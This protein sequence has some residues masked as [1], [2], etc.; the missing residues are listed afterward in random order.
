MESNVLEL[1]EKL[2]RS[3]LKTVS[4]FANFKS[5]KIV[6][7]I[8]DDGRILGLDDPDKACLD[9]ENMINDSIRPKP[10]YTFSIDRKT[11]VLTLVVS[12]GLYKPYLYKGKAYRR[13][14]T[15]SVEVDQVELRRLVLEGENL[16]F[17]ELVIDDDNLTFEY[18]F[19]ALKKKLDIDIPSRDLLKTLGLLR[20][21]GK[22]NNA[23]SLLADKNEFS[24][25]DLIKFTNSINNIVK[26]KT[27]IN[28]SILIQLDEAEEMFN[29]YY[30]IEE[31]RGMERRVKYLIPLEA[32][33]ETVANALVHRMWDID[34]NIRISM[35]DDR[36]EIS[37]P[38]GLLSNISE[39]EYL[40][41]FISY[42]RNP[43]I[44][45]VFFRLGIIEKF[46]T[47]IR[48]IKESY[49]DFKNQ[50]IFN[51]N[52]N[53]IVTILPITDMKQALTREEEIVC[54]SFDRNILLSSTEL[55][56]KTGF[57]KDKILSILNSLID[58]SYV[59]RI[60]RGRGTKYKLV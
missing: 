8:S 44:A 9:I 37:S 60:G 11:R 21:D 17:D 36:I 41:G 49:K 55:V 18:L 52:K 7:G 10:D 32:F 20:N 6:F 33:R 42:L 25:I 2:T 13:S 1:K 59:E 29:D 34:S 39:E 57:G 43:T 28:Q 50:P 56:A 16:Y 40:N 14:G 27:L 22:F 54:D 4:A 38:G 35:F 15:S 47:G 5:G 24:G 51:V 46:G 45:N 3:F 12:E 30:R 26:R 23:A 58:K 31:I 19:K 53:S 48:R